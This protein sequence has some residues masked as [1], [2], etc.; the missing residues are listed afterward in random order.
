MS[1]LSVLCGSLGLAVLVGCAS[2][3]PVPVGDA[4]PVE[5]L[6]SPAAAGSG[7]PNLLS[8]SDGKLYLSWIEPD[9]AGHALRFSTWEGADWSVPRT[10]AA[11]DNWFVNWA[12]FPSMAALADGTLAAH[13]LVRS[14]AETY[15]YDVLLSV[16]SDGGNTWTAPVRPHDDGTATE[17]GFASLVPLDDAFLVVWLDGRRMADQPPGPMTLRQARLERDGSVGPDS[18]VDDSVCD[19]CPTDAQR[20]DDGILVVYRDRTPG[21][22]RDVYAARLAGD[23]WSAPAA[24]HADGWV[25]AGCPV[26]GPAVDADGTRVAVAWFTG[27]QGDPGAVR[28]AFSEDAGRTFAAPS[29]IDD[30]RPLGRVDVTLLDDGSALVSWLETLG[31]S[32]A[33]QVR[34][35]TSA[36]GDAA[37]LEVTRTDVS[38][39]SGFPKLNRHG[40]HV[41]VAWTETGDPTR[42]STARLPVP[43]AP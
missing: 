15:A 3:T 30:G 39:S 2:S 35:V 24:V 8:G 36:G 13:W 40:E 29:T 26:N 18:I 43:R 31:G 1:R 37:V 32:A 16:S 10:I 5:R 9:G 21:E 6:G 19:C 12:D 4:G 27:A 42:V 17:H 38:R 11:G 20:M 23:T 28:L 7:E 14:A 41:F 33:I 22:V 25:I 34:R